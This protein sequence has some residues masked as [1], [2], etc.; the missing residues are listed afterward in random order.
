MTMV[1]PVRDL[2]RTSFACAVSS[3]TSIF[4]YFLSLVFVAFCLQYALVGQ[5]SKPENRG[6]DQAC[7]SSLSR[8]S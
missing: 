7:S 2:K 6:R 8:D 1:I 3:P 5:V 4:L